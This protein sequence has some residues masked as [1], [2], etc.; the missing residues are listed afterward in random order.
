M[1]QTM[2]KTSVPLSLA[3]V[4][5]LGALSSCGQNDNKTRNAVS[6]VGTA[7]KTAGKTTKVSGVAVVCAA[8]R[9]TK[10]W[11]ETAVS[12]VPRKKCTKSGAIKKQKSVV[13]VCGVNKKKRN[14]G[15]QQNHYPF[16]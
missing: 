16:E 1:F 13:V 12:K 10:V 15:L 14:Y 8:T 9:S 7:C 6:P 4:M 5:S 3:L 11:Y 2:K